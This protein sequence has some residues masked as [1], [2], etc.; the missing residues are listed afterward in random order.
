MP[1][2]ILLDT[3]PVIAH[4]RD[5]IDITVLAPQGAL[6]FTSLFTVGELSKGVH[7]AGSPDSERSKID[8]FMQ[9]V[10]VLIPDTA[11]AEL[12]GEVSAALERAGKRIPE[13]DVW[14][15]ATALECGMAVAT[16]DAH[17]ERVPGLDVLKW[18]W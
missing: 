2:D 15:A 14:I 4:L 11:T 17:F 9:H 7:K 6:L 18:T 5:K 16:A 3:A 12:Y 1:K 13:N 8:A 10:A